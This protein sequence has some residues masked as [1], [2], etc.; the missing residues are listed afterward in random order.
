MVIVGAFATYTY[1]DDNV[2][3]FFSDPGGAIAQ[4]FNLVT[5]RAVNKRYVGGRSQHRR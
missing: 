1:A 2:P 3:D 4:A 5:G